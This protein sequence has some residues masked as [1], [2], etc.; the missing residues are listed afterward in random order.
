MDF[1]SCEGCSRD[2]GGGYCRI[3]MEAECRE[4]GGFELHTC[5]KCRRLEA[6]K[7][8]RLVD[9]IVFVVFYGIACALCG[10]AAL[11]LYYLVF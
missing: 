5:R 7:H 1:N 3:S 10:A 4:G 11:K 6:L 9:N 8:Q 2:L